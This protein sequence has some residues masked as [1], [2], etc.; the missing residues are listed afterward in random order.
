MDGDGVDPQA[1]AAVW[2][3]DAVPV[4]WGCLTPVDPLQYYCHK[5]GTA[6]GQL[7]PTLPYIYI[8]FMVSLIDR[9]WTRIWFPRWESGGRRFGYFLIMLVLALF[10]GYYWI[11][12]ICAPLM[13]GYRRKAARIGCCAHCDYDLRASRDRCP[14]CGEAF[15]ED[16]SRYPPT[17]F[18]FRWR[19]LRVETAPAAGAR[20]DAHGAGGA[21]D[22]MQT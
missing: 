12:F 15:S 9:M 20:A 1:E 14:E 11:P 4:C 13:L 2:A 5:C 17:P 3:P 16:D 8:P 10:N 6:T 19:G 7:T 21:S 18:A 22:A